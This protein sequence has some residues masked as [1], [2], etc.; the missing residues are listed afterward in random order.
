MKIKA[1]GYESLMV[2]AVAL[3][4]CSAAIAGLIFVAAKPFSRLVLILGGM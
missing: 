1:K 4:I 2:F 3:T